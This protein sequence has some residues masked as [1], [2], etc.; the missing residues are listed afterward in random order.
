MNRLISRIRAWLVSLIREAVTP[1]EKKKPLPGHVALMRLRAAASL[2]GDG[3]TI[4]RA[5]VAAGVE[6]EDL[7]HFLRPRSGARGSA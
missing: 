2:V 5:A 4:A 3:E 1:I 7:R 6:P